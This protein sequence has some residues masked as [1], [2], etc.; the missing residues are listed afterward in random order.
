MSFYFVLSALPFLLVMSGLLGWVSTTSKWIEFAGW[1]TS[2]LPWQ[3]Q[4]AVL[5]GMLE[6]AKGYG[7]FLSL[8][9]ILTMWSASTGFLSLMDALSVAYGVKERRSYFKR[10]LIAVCATVTAA[11][12]IILCFGIWNV[13]HFLAGVIS[14]DFR[15]VALYP[16]QWKVARW[17][18]TLLVICLGVDLINYFLPGSRRPWR[19]M[20]AGTVLTVSVFLVASALLNLYIG[21]NP[22]VSRIYGALAGFIFLMLWIYIGSLSLLVGAET[23]VALSELAGRGTVA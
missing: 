16:V 22:E 9:L 14:S 10:R 8:G 7:A 11:F 18:A 19:W 12:F 13:G 2:Y 17:V 15:F 6:L 5:A 4:R 23:D 3:A 20:T 21:H 1:L